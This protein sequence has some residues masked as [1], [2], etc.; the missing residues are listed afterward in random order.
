[1]RTTNPAWCI[2]QTKRYIGHLLEFLLASFSVAMLSYSIENFKVAYEASRHA[3]LDQGN[4]NLEKPTVI[5]IKHSK[6]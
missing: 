3:Y 4:Q 2:K 5:L 1:M 6:L